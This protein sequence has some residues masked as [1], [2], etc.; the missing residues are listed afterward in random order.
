MVSRI[1]QLDSIM[2]LVVAGVRFSQFSG[3]VPGRLQ[4]PV[5]DI[6]NFRVLQ[7]IERC[8]RGA[9]RRCYLPF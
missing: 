3:P 4:G 7:N 1:S 8:G 6:T 9:A 2:N 5:E